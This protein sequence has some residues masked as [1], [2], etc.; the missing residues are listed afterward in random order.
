LNFLWV[1]THKKRVF[2][3]SRLIKNSATWIFYEV[4]LVKIS[5]TWFQVAEFFNSDFFLKTSF[6]WVKTHKKFGN[7]N[8]LWGLTGK[9]FGD[10]ISGCRIF[11]ESWLVKI[12]VTWFQVAE[13]FNSDFFLKTSF[14]WVKTHKK[15]GN[16]NF[17]WGLTGKN[18]G[19]L[20]SGCRIFYESW[21]V[22]ISVTWF[23]VAEFFNSDFFLKTSFL[24]VKTHKKFGNLN[25]LW[26]LTGK[27]F[28]DLI[29]GCRI[30]YES[31]LVKISVTWFQVAEF[32][33]SD[34]FLKTSFL[35]VK[36]HKKFGNLNFLWGLTGKNFGDLISGCRIFYESWLVKISVTWFQVAEFFNS[37]FFLKTSFLWVKTHKKFGNLNFLWGLT[38]KNFGD[39]ISGCRI[40]YE[41]WLVKISVTWFQ[42]AEFF[43]SDFFLKTSFL[44]VKTHKNSATWIFYES[45]LIKNEF[46][47]SQDS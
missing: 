18:F 2:Y 5:V 30:F 12:S 26:G 33:N 39:L 34:F 10:L 13:F 44:W 15:F 29:S 41:S 20:I 22:K 19:D 3:E 21:L 7:L 11:Y 36:T 4:W 37:D 16:L 40:F 1:L 46:F 23:Q 24:W 28:G 35:W 6:L 32:F 9:N 31:W 17:L 38:G 42:V 43:N 14:L 27:N 47:M 25:F 45:W 8:F